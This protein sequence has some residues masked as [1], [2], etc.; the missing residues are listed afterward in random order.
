M[1][2]AISY[3]GPF[4]INV[5]I[6]PRK[7]VFEERDGSFDAKA[8]TI[9][10]A[11]DLVGV[12]FISCL[13]HEFTH[14]TFYFYG[15]DEILGDDTEEVV[16]FAL[17]NSLTQMLLPFLSVVDV[18]TEKKPEATEAVTTPQEPASS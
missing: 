14:A 18:P 3:C 16:T 13:L 17:G 12:E 7:E 6:L 4:P 15:V 8:R 11:D 1:K 9:C 2:E 5:K 10:I